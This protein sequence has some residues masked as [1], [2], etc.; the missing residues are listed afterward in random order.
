LLYKVVSEQDQPL[1]DLAP[2]ARFPVGGVLLISLPYT[3]D[4]Y[5]ID[6]VLDLRQLTAQRWFAE[7]FTEI[8]N[9]KV[10][11]HMAMQDAW[12]DVRS[13]LDILP[14]LLDQREGGG[15]TTMWV[16]QWLMDHDVQA[17]VYPSARSNCAVMYKSFE[18]VQMFG[19]CLVDYRGGETN[20]MTGCII[21]GDPWDV[22][23]A[24]EFPVELKVGG[25]NAASWWVRGPQEVLAW[26]LS[27]G[28]PK[29]NP[30]IFG[31][32]MAIGTDVV[33]SLREK[34]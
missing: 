1:A 17:L 8:A 33:V 10:L 4:R 3:I 27:R 29:A 5:D 16:G 15:D 21:V 20:P 6:G 11:P 25:P 2:N 18:P 13:F 7:H 34:T 23:D 22:N 30:H 28:D 26:K 19:F 9:F 14:I 24:D 31:N 32:E 12:T